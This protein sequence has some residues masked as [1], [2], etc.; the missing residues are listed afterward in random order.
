MSYPSV[1]PHRKWDS[2]FR[3]FSW[4]A[5][6]AEGMEN[7]QAFLAVSLLCGQ[8]GS[9]SRTGCQ[10]RVPGVGC[11]E[12]KHQGWEK[13]GRNGGGGRGD[14]SGASAVTTTASKW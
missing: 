12:Q 5:R 9:C 10:R 7:S 2:F 14:L 8:S 11:W 3:T 1:S 6:A 4:P 13:G